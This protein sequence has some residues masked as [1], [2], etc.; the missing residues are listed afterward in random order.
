MKL[1][2]EQSDIE[3]KYSLR[4]PGL[5]LFNTVLEVIAFTAVCEYNA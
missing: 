3:A 5:S 1:S 4:V 2:K